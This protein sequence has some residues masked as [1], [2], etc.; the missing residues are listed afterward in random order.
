MEAAGLVLG[1]IPL[2]IKGLQTY[3]DILSSMKSAQRDL[4]DMISILTAEQQILQN[5]CQILLRGIV[6]N[7]Q[8]DAITADPCGPD[9]K[10]YDVEIDTRLHR[11]STVFKKTVTEMK[12]AVDELQ[13][14]LA[15]TENGEVRISL[16]GSKLSCASIH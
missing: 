10:K 5:T 2:V 1:V 12:K 9:W 7:S 13:Q 3:R 4:D 8:L 6:P 14:K 16:D 11:S 15:V